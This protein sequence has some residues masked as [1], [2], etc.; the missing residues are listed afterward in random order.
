MMILGIDP[1]I[2]GALAFLSQGGK[3]AYLF[4]MPIMQTG[5]ANAK[6]KNVVN[7]AALAKIFRAQPIRRCL[8]ERISTMPGQGV[9]TQGSMM[10]GFGTIDGVLQAIGISYELVSPVSWKKHFGLKG[11]PE[12][13]EVSRTLAQRWYPEA[14]LSLK[15]HHNRAEAILIARWGM[16]KR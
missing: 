14:D 5:G 12:N 15:K 16:A 4:D 6:A 11:G 7:G 1:G 2:S 9:A 10:R 13:K 3:V 8:L